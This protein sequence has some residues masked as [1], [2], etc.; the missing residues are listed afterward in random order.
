[1][2]LAERFDDRLP[3]QRGVFREE[4]IGEPMQTTGDE[5]RRQN[6]EHQRHAER[7][8]VATRGGGFDGSARV[9][10]EERQQDTDPHHVATRGPFPA[11]LI[12][13]GCHAQP[14]SQRCAATVNRAAP[15]RRLTRLGTQPEQPIDGRPHVVLSRVRAD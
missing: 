13:S 8:S 12:D 14:I 10:G 6:A 2:V 1:M 9:G 3:D 11:H 4:R 15:V 5:V 7:N